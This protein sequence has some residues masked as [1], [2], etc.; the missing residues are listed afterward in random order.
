VGSPNTALNLYETG[1]A[2]IVWDKDLVP[3]ELMDILKRRPDVHNYTLL[4]S[5]FYR[6]NVKRKPFDDPNVRKAFAL[7]TDRERLV[8]KLTLA[9]EKPAY[10]LVPDKV[11]DYEPPKGLTFD[12]EAARELAKAG[13]LGARIPACDTILFGRERWRKNAGKIAV[14]LSRCGG[15]SGVNVPSPD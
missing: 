6:F 9:G 7:A 2:D 15:E 11:A 12:P 4:G 3:T 5:C 13:F 10:S 8:R 1:V 14:E